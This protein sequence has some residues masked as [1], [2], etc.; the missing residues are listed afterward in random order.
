MECNM[1]TDEVCTGYTSIAKLSSAVVETLNM[2]EYFLSQV[3]FFLY[4]GDFNWISMIKYSDYSEKAEKDL[5]GTNL[6]IIVGMYKTAT[7]ARGYF[8]SQP[9]HSPPVALNLLTNA[10]LR[11]VPNREDFV[12]D[13]INYPL[14]PTTIDEIDNI[15][16]SQSS[17]FNIGFTISFG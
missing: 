9:F 12:I 1:A 7:V 2:T 11:A 4:N 3:M 15:G 17:G 16:N 14:P 10:F 13:V 6:G 8:N 5:A